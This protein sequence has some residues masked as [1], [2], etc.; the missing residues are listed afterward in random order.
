MGLRSFPWLWCR[1]LPSLAYLMA[2]E[3]ICWHWESAALSLVDPAITLEKSCVHWLPTSWNWGMPTYWTPGRP[4]RLV[5]PGLAIGAA[6]MAAS[7]LAAKA[8]AA[9]WYC[10]IW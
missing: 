9:F 2:E 5:V 10:G 4:G 7:V 6:F 8:A 1:R 3:A